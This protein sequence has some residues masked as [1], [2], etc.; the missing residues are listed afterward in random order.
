M[1]DSQ[2]F[3]ERQLLLQGRDRLRAVGGV[4]DASGMRLEREEGR[5]RAVSLGG[6]DS[7]ADDID[8]T[9]MNAVEA[10]DSDGRGPD[11]ARGEP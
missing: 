5:L 2:R 8:V 4:E 9:E 6:G 3:H 7:A 11:R 1:L 10:A